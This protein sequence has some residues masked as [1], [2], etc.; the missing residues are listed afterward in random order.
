MFHGRGGTVGRGGGPT[1]L[2]LLSQ[3]PNTINGS[4]RVT[5]QGE[6]IEQ[7]FGEEH[8]CFRTLQ[9]YTAVT[10]EHGMCP[11]FSPRPEWRA[12]LDNMAVV[13]TKKFRSIILEDPQFVTYFRMV[14][15][16]VFLAFSFFWGGLKSSVLNPL[17]PLTRS[18]C[19]FL[20]VVSVFLCWLNN[21]IKR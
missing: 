10:L 5:V 14:S 21:L 2:T 19:L 6:V 13:G 15:P 7:S 9:R 8:L 3:P 1:H 17:I 11:S 12:L 4:L 20:L 16:L 18:P